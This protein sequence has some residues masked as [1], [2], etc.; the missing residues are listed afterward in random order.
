MIMNDN[1][2]SMKNNE[3]SMKNNNVIVSKFTY[4]M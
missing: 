4:Y 1:E 3:L 2:L